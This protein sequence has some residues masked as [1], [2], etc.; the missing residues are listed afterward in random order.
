MKI[1]NL[2]IIIFST[3][4]IVSCGGDLS[5][6]NNSNFNQKLNVGIGFLHSCVVL[7][8]G[9]LKCA[10]S[11]NGYA[12]ASQTRIKSNT[13]I[14]ATNLENI[15][16]VTSG[17]SFSCALLEDQTVSCWGDQA[18]GLISPSA[19]ASPLNVPDLSGVLQ[20]ASGSQ[21]ACA[22]LS[23]GQIKCWGE[24]NYGQLGNNST[25]DS[26]TPIIVL[27]VNTAT[28]ITAQYDHTCALL[29][30]QTVQCWGRNNNGQLGDETTTDKLVPTNV[31]NLN[32]A[33][34]VSVG[35]LHGC[36]L[37]SLNRV[38]CWGSDT[39]LK[40]NS[41]SVGLGIVETS[42]LTDVVDLALGKRHSCAVRQ[43]GQVRCW[44]DGQSGALGVDENIL[45]QEGLDGRSTLPRTVAGLS[46]IISIFSKYKSTC[47]E[48]TAHELKCW[49]DNEYGQLGI[50]KATVNFTGPI[51]VPQYDS[52]SFVTIGDR[53][54]LSL[55]S[56][57]IISGLGE[58]ISN[59][60]GI[61]SD[62]VGGFEFSSTLNPI[63]TDSN[64]TSL[65]SV[66]GHACYSLQNGTVKCWGSN[67]ELALGFMPSSDPTL[68]PGSVVGLTQVSKVVVGEFHNCALLSTG[69][70]RCWGD[71]NVGNLGNG[72]TTSSQTP[73]TVTGLSN[74]TDLSE[75]GRTTCAVSSGLVYCWG[76][77]SSTVRTLG[78]SSFTNQF[79]ST[80]LQV[81]GVNN[82]TKVSVGLRS[83]CAL[84][85]DGT[86][87]CW[88]S[89]FVGQRGNLNIVD[90]T[91][92]SVVTGISNAID[93]QAGN[94]FSCAL[95]STNT[96]KCWGTNGLGQIGQT[97]TT[98]IDIVNEAFEVGEPVT[99]TGLTNV[100]SLF[101]GK[102]S[103]CAKTVSNQMYCWGYGPWGELG[104]NVLS[105]EYNPSD[106][107]L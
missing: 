19:S 10:G 105:F 49:G 60:L 63:Q 6:N 28:Q 11:N 62:L 67:D 12:L 17:D 80:P 83:S 51:R 70:V 53:S 79:S 29:S 96:V 54:V 33:V 81:T 55:S 100:N 92:A 16:Q 91:V 24:N 90:A 101:V 22:L 98:V 104:N 23:T 47:A 50:N 75:G 30:N 99:V 102:N 106:V 87:K 46:G 73:V 78:N 72:T 7:R 36:A 69:A 15:R 85:N 97:L 95:L 2:F 38:K 66:Y 27:G 65:E 21:H 57:S 45:Y 59:V 26:D 13:F 32:D 18:L 88:G 42:G 82:A 64:I 89:T 40:G 94:D 4:V 31:L 52:E 39:Y 71:N 48:T 8:S 93:V 25:T 37:T 107:S 76:F 3:T 44:G 1:L 103:T 5:P 56:V 35:E 43:N 77:N 9:R 84:I 41:T 68:T 34:K 61:E 74:A 20:L 14:S 58:N 86:I